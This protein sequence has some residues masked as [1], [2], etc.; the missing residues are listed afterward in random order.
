MPF[1]QGFQ[2]VEQSVSESHELTAV[3]V[4]LSR[5]NDRAADWVLIEK[6]KDGELIFINNKIIVC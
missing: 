2:I 6:T 5:D 4:D 3:S 1:L